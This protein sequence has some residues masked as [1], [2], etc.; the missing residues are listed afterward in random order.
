[1]KL[2]LGRDYDEILEQ[3]RDITKE[4]QV[5]IVVL[6]MPLLDTR[7]KERDLTTSFV[8]ELV[9]QILSYVSEKERLLNQERQAAGIAAAHERGVKF[10]RKPKERPPEL[11]DLKE[12]FEAGE[13]TSTEAAKRLNVSR[14][15]F[16]RWIGKL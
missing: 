16:M 2:T 13:I 5:Y 9:L 6:D 8:S 10:G 3:W 1:L 7:Q 12:L 4:R 15:T 11:T 14:P